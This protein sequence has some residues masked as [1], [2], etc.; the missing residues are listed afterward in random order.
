MLARSGAGDDDTSGVGLGF[1]GGVI[2]LATTLCV[3]CAMRVG[4]GVGAG[5]GVGVGVAVGDGAG[6]GVAVGTG[7][8]EGATSG[9]MPSVA[10]G[11]GD[12]RRFGR[13]TCPRPTASAPRARAIAEASAI[14]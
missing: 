8:G 10:V 14:P 7:D 1:F 13:E 4:V 11:R 6:V 5:A 12:G 9:L 2:A 3:F